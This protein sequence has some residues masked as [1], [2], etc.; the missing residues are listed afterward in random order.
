VLKCS[1]VL[2]SLTTLTNPL[3][4]VVWW[5]CVPVPPGGTVVM[6]PVVLASFTNPILN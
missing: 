4:T 6:C 3:L 5:W 2:A 1:V